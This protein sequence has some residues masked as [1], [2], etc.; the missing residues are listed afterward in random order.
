MQIKSGCQVLVNCIFPDRTFL[1]D[2]H[3]Y[4]SW[5]F[6]LK[7]IELYLTEYFKR[8]LLWSYINY[9]L[10]LTNTRE[11]QTGRFMNEIVGI[12]PECPKNSVSSNS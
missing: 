11:F 12:S 3:S 5:V 6:S 9:S 1:K 7:Y 2:K 8:K 10:Q 4:H